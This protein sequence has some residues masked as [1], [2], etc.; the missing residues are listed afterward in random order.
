VFGFLGVLHNQ[1]ANEQ[2]DEWIEML[3]P[4]IDGN[5]KN[6]ILVIYSHCDNGANTAWRRNNT[7]K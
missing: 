4:K 6:K 7:I 5:D 1:R 2:P 3:I